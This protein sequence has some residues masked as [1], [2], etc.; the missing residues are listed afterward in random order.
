MGDEDP[1]LGGGDGFLP[2]LGQAAASSQPCEGSFDDPSAR[3]D[4]EA[5]GGIGSLDDLD[6]PVAG[7]PQRLPQLRAGVAAVGEDVAQPG[8]A[9]ADGFEH[10][11]RA[12]A[13]LNRGGM[14]DQTDHQA[15]GVG[16]YVTLATLDPLASIVAASSSAFSGFHAR[17]VDHAR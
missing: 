4:L 17:A 16:H 15:E 14:D 10:G 1:S 6:P 13:V 11:R 3:Q 12:V 8:P 2:V 5:L 7:A 9:G